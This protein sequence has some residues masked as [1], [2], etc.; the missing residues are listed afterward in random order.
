MTTGKKKVDPIRRELKVL[1]SCAS[2]NR[3]EELHQWL[4]RV[5]SRGQNTNWF[6]AEKEWGECPS[7]LKRK[8]GEKQT[9]TKLA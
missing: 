1:F 4:L 9:F 2:V 3:F 7:G 5:I 6:G 8:G